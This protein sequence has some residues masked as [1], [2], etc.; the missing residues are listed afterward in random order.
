[1]STVTPG[2]QSAWQPFVP[3]SMAVTTSLF[4]WA[5]R[6]MS[7]A[8]VMKYSYPF[9]P[10]TAVRDTTTSS[11]FERV[12]SSASTAAGGESQ[13]T[14]P[15]APPVV[16]VAVISEPSWSRNP[17]ADVEPGVMVPP[18]LSTIR[19]ICTSYV[20]CANDA[21]PKLAPAV[22]S[23]SSARYNLSA[24]EGVTL[25]SL[26][27]WPVTGCPTRI[28]SPGAKLP[29]RSLL[30]RDAIDVRSSKSRVF[31][32]FSPRVGRAAPPMLVSSL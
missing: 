12:S 18:E 26:K 29:R 11:M 31:T 19:I 27:I 8:K 32:K 3:M 17:D 24:A 9:G 14:H 20:E 30:V 4:G 25:C 23:I 6:T 7:P 28:R 2:P 1:M 13:R 22:G 10:V 5:P 15:A 16:V 21:G